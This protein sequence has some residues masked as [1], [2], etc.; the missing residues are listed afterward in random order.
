MTSRDIVQL[1][2]QNQHITG[3]QSEK[4]R[5]VVCWMGA[6]QAQ[7]YPAALWAVGLRTRKA[8]AESVEQAIAERTIIR[9]WPMRGTL[10]FVTPADVRWMLKYLTPRI[11]ARAAPRLREL[12]LDEATFSQSETVFTKALQGGRQRTRNAMYTL[13]ERNNISCAGQRGMHILWKLA[14]DGLICFGPRDGK[15]PTFVLLDEWI[16]GKKIIPREEAIAELTN[17]F[18]SSH[19]PATLKDFIWWS[20]LTTAEA[21]SGL[22]EVKTLFASQSVDGQTYWFPREHV[23]RRRVTQSVHLLPAFDEYLVGYKDRN[24]AVESAEARRALPGGG[25]LRAT[26]ILDGR[27]IGT[28]RRT[29][30]KEE[31]AID[32]DPFAPLDK[33]QRRGIE[34]VAARYGK[35][36]GKSVTV[37]TEH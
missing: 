3:S 22:E 8:T 14:Q 27:I 1:R 18:F 2:Q 24:A 7:D 25:I 23:A 10:H 30:V 16:P 32:V 26:V 9:T 21:R 11:V 17:R 13:L 33:S 4:P 20:G 19:G 15:Q 34:E 29:I 35:F 31:V 28:W 5:D 12:N 6:V 37:E 36:L